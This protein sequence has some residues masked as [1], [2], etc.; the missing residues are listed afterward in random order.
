MELT[1][2][3]P[4]RDDDM[5]SAMLRKLTEVLDNAG[6]AATHGA[7]GG[8]YGYG[9]DYDGPEFMMHHYCWCDYD[10]CPWCASHEAN[11]RH[12]PTGLEVRW[13]KYIGRGMEVVNPSTEE[14]WRIVLRAINSLK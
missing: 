14:P 9:A 3:L 12:K 10:D 11:F 1:I 6:H 5:L 8:H 13:Y 2:V 7:L 4:E